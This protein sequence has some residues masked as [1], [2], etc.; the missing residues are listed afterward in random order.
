MKY[1][2]N[3]FQVDIINCIN[4]CKAEIV[5]RKK[6]ISGESTMEQLENVI[7][8][9]LEALL[10]KAKV[11]NLPPKADRYLNSF[12]NAFRV[13]GWDMETPTE[14]FVKLTELNNNYR[15]LEE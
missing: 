4:L 6:D 12:A 15:D 3:S 8:P 11:G 14:L 1:T 10:Q 13:W 5:K 2:I 7:L 9:E